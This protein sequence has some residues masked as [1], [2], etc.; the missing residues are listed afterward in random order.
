AVSD[1]HSFHR[2]TPQKL[3][4]VLTPELAGALKNL[5]L[6]TDPGRLGCLG[7]V[8]GIGGFKEVLAESQVGKLPSGDFRFLRLEPLIQAKE[9]AGR[10]RDLTHLKYLKPLNERRVQS[11]KNPKT[12]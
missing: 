7:H 2:M 6:Q 3:P 9:A 10:E 1:L 5:Y 8:E 11:A 12:D 4:F